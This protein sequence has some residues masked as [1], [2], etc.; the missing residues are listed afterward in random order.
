M[1][2]R[3]TQS[4]KQVPEQS[5]LHSEILSETGTRGRAGEQGDRGERRG[6]EAR[7]ERRGQ[8]VRVDYI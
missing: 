7:G 2:S 8:G 3:L 6:G 4:T 5:Q 1:D